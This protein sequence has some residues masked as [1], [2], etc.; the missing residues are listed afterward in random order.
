M[1]LTGKQARRIGPI[2]V[3]VG[4]HGRCTF[5][6]QI[7]QFCGVWACEFLES[8]TAEVSR[9]AGTLALA[10]DDCVVHELKVQR[11]IYKVSEDEYS[12]NS[13]IWPIGEL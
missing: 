13:I 3:D 4:E 6:R 12:C 8:S 1:A 10:C 9:V 11:A 5:V 7:I 2:E